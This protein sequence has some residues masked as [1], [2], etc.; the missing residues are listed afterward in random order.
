MSI[1]FDQILL[2]ILDWI[3]RAIQSRRGKAI[4]KPYE[5]IRVYPGDKGVLRQLKRDTARAVSTLEFQPHRK[6]GQPL[7]NRVH[8]YCDHLEKLPGDPTPRVRGK[9]HRLQILEVSPVLTPEGYAICEILLRQ[10]YQFH[11]S[12]YR[13]EFAPT[14]LLAVGFQLLRL[15]YGAIN[16]EFEIEASA[17]QIM[18]SRWAKI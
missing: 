11:R 16:W 9:S 8:L 1:R 7:P 3:R 2:E 12:A 10:D 15:P 13:D 6:A 5:V 17:K 14:I 4:A 18:G